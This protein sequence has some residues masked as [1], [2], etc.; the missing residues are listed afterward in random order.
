MNLPALRRLSLPLF[1]LALLLLNTAGWVWVRHARLCAPEAECA[2]EAADVED[3]STAA[4]ATAPAIRP[5]MYRHA[6]MHTW[7]PWV[8]RELSPDRSTASS[9]RQA[10]NSGTGA[11]RIM[12]PLPAVQGSVDPQYGWRVRSKR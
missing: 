5:P 10:K 12:L 6:S 11:R 2:A 9:G 1:A 8:V 4:P 3:D 7:T